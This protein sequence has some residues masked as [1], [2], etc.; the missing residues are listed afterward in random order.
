[1]F[2][3]AVLPFLPVE[4]NTKHGEKSWPPMQQKH[5][6][7]TDKKKS[8]KVLFWGGCRP[9]FYSTVSE[10]TVSKVTL[11][12]A[13]NSRVIPY[14]SYDLRSVTSTTLI[15]TCYYSLYLKS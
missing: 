1:M 11:Y 2:K 3:M 8:W 9:T 15:I 10:P 13:K 12:T 4:K 6:Y 5:Q 7:Y 14:S